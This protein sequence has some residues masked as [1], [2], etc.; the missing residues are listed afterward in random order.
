MSRTKSAAFLFVLVAACGG[1]SSPPPTTPLPDDQPAEPKVEETK[2]AEPAPEA[3]PAPQPV[4]VNLPASKATVKLTKPGKGKKAPL[5]YKFAVGPAGGVDLTMDM[6]FTMGTM[7]NSMTM[8]LGL[9]NEILEVGADGTIKMKQSLTSASAEAKDGQGNAAPQS[10]DAIIGT[11]IEATMSSHG[12]PGERKVTTPPIE[13]PAMV[14]TLTQIPHLSIALPD[15]PV[16]T[17]ATWEVSEP[18][19]I[20]G[21]DATVTTVYKLVS[22]KGKTTTIEGNSTV[23]GGAQAGADAAQQMKIDEIKGTGKSTFV[24]EEGKLL[25]KTDAN[26]TLTIKAT[27][28]GQQPQQMELVLVT[29]LSAAGK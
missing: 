25:A 7:A 21:L 3:K 15:K 11:T 18:L 9:A 26:Q 19:G 20:E 2:P 14:Q 1:K 10:L 6:S 22:R 12:V 28:Q 29:H 24:L 4:T 17:G 5:E 8:K 27:V 23:T 16:G 13:D